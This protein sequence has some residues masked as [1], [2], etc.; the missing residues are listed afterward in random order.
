MKE[1]LTLNVFS[2]YWTPGCKKT[3]QIA[4]FYHRNNKRDHRIYK[5]EYV[6]V[7]EVDCMVPMCK[8]F[9]IISRLGNSFVYF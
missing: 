2:D 3:N 9:L 4:H 5:N 6:K 7:K 1:N 8:C